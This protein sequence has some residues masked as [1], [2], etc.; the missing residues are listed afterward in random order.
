MHL[1]KWRKRV[2]GKTE[3]YWALVESYRTARGPRQRIVAYLG[4]VTEPVREGVA[5]AARG[6]R[7]HQPSLLE[8][9]PPAW[10][11]VDTRR[12]RVERV[13][14][15]GGPWLG[16]QLIEMVGLEGWLRETLPAGREEI[17]WAAMAQV[18]VLGRL[19]DPSSELALA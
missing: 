9:E 2:N 6:Q 8:A 1:R 4:D 12:L 7:H 5:R 17:P 3:E 13:R 15:F 16:R 18:L 14:D 10:V 19:C 11:E